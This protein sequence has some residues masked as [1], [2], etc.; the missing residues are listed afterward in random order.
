[1]NK[2]VWALTLQ[3]DG[4]NTLVMAAQCGASLEDQEGSAQTSKVKLVLLLERDKSPGEPIVQ[5]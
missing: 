5:F 4:G 1:M 3:V 2:M